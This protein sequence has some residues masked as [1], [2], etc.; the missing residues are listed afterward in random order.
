ME[1][2][3]IK[4]LDVLRVIAMAMVVMLHTGAYYQATE[5]TATTVPL[6]L[7]IALSSC[8]VPLFFMISGALLLSPEYDLSVKRVLTKL[9]KLIIV[10]IIWSALYALI[11]NPGADFSK[12]AVRT[13]KGPFHFW[14][15]EYLAAVYLL[16]PI[17]KALVSYQNGR[18]VKYILICWFVLGILK[19]TLNGIQWHNE[20]IGVLTGKIHFELSDFS[21]YF[22]LGYYLSN[23]KPMSHSSSIVWAL[24][25]ISAAVLHGLVAYCG[26]LQVSTYNLSVLVAIES[27]CVFM[28]CR[29]AYL[30]DS[31]SSQRWLE[32]LSVSS[33]GVYLIH[34]IIMKFVARYICESLGVTFRSL[35]LFVTVLLASWS[36]SL[37]LSKIPFTRKWLLSI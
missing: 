13:F 31:R 32:L 15:F 37:L 6:S 14:F 36:V 35:L 8:A 28:V 23:L 19:F 9:M 22:L 5:M 25:Y 10:W 12:L 17:M 1:K 26:I 11:D 29:S 24:G 27:A 3:R 30:Q 18:F 21:G 4:Y 2:G 34:P 20:E 33:M 16:S 7:L